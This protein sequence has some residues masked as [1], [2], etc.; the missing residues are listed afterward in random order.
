MGVEGET[1]KEIIGMF[2]AEYP[3]V[4]MVVQSVPWGTAHEKMITAVAGGVGPDVC[5]FGTTWI[6]EFV[7]LGALES[8]DNYISASKNIAKENYFEGSWDTGV[9]DKVN[10]GIPWYVDTRVLFYRTDLLK[11][12]GY[13]H[14]PRTW[15]ELKDASRKLVQR[16]EK[17]GI[18]RTAIALSAV[19]AKTLAMFMWSNGGDIFKPDQGLVINSPE[20]AEALDFYASFFKEGQSPLIAPGGLELYTHF[21]TGFVP[22]FIGGPWM[23]K[24]LDTRTPEIAGRWNVATLPIKKTGTSFVGGSN[25]CIFKDS[26]NKELAWKFIEFM[27]RPD[28]QVQWYRLTTD[29]PTRVEAW[30]DPYFKDK[31]KIK[32]FGQQL[33]HTNSPPRIQKWEE[34]EGQINLEMEKVVNGITSAAEALKKLEISISKILA[35]SRP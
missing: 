25:L 16:N 5:Q 27:S 1:L 11:D 21:K 3:E 18:T 26:K 9:I 6:P 7:A 19:D 28:I 29:L 17:G 8:L 34:I 15:A 2:K 30:E 4:E 23:L 32:V 12:V 20:N 33:F 14:A 10:Y 22:M 31:P 24:D 35:K 13:D